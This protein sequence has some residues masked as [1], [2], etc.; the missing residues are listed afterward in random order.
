M[1]QR[2]VAEQLHRHIAILQ[3]QRLVVDVAHPPR[4]VDPF[5]NFNPQQTGDGRRGG[6]HLEGQHLTHHLFTLLAQHFRQAGQIAGFMMDVFT[7]HVSSR[8]VATH[9]QSPV[10]QQIDG[11]ANS[12]ARHP[13]LLGQFFLS[14]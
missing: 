11:F 10:H 8:A 4:E 9:N 3:H 1:T 12:H 6:H 14:W 13:E 2:Q 7:R 5:I